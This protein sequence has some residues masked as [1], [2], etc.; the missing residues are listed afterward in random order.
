MGFTKIIHLLTGEGDAAVGIYRNNQCQNTSEATWGVNDLY[1][2][3]EY[4]APMYSHAY[5]TNITNSKISFEATEL[6]FNS[7]PNFFEDPA[8]YRVGSSTRM[9]SIWGMSLAGK[10]ATDNAPC[11]TYRWFC[12]GDNQGSWSG[13]PIM[14]T[15]S[16]VASK[17][18]NIP[19]G[20]NGIIFFSAKSRIQGNRLNTSGESATF[21]FGIKIDGVK[22]GTVGVQK[23]ISPYV[24]SSRSITA[25]YLSAPNTLSPGNHTVQVYAR[26]QGNIKWALITKDLPLIYFD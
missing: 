12:I 13:C 20:H 26:A 15:E 14:N 4:Q 9:V 19:Q 7:E 10:I 2:G 1:R 5:H 11:S 22:V 8:C 25:S 17:T 3:A 23:V 16:I 18:I 21:Y 6:V 24:E